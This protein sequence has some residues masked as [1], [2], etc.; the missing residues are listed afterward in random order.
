MKQ[1]RIF[2]AI[3]FALCLCGTRARAQ[4]EVDPTPY[5]LP[6]TAQYKPAQP[7]AARAVKQTSTPAGQPASTKKARKPSSTA[8]SSKDARVVAKR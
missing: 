1:A 8:A 6:R 3:L 7:A 2:T 5:P 4:Q